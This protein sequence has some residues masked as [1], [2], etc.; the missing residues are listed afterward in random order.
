MARPRKE[1]MDYFPHDT[2][3]VNDTKIEALRMLYG[4]N[5]YAFYFILLELIYKQ[6]N[7]ELDVSD[8]ETMQILAKK[9]EVTQEEF[10]KMLATAIKRECFDPVAY[11]ERQVLTSEGIKKRSKVV[12]EKRERMRKKPD[13]TAVSELLQGY[14]QVSA[15]ETT[16]EST[17]RKVK[18]K[19]SKSK[20]KVIEYTPE[21]NEFWNVYPRK[22]G[23][24]E[25]FKTW[26]KVTNNGESHEFITKCAKNYAAD[27]KAK[28]TAD[29]FIKHPKS[30][31][32]DE[33][34]KDYAV[35]V[36]GGGNGG[37]NGRYDARHAE[38]NRNDAS[39]NEELF[40]GKFGHNTIENPEEFDRMLRNFE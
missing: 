5:G 34:Y 28:Q 38:A 15:A 3:A 30:F 40:I 37:K 11:Q 14:G 16:A 1:G 9:V 33:R 26:K 35:I 24:L 6:P 31:L 7:F 23:K 19:E 21:F 29:Q 17:Q 4:N 22:V 25:C 10:G 39:K 20:G 18:V 12:V 13:A 32:N 27:C 36:I 8:A 2:D